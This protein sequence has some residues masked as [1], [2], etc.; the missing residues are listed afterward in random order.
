MPRRKNQPAK[1]RGK[2]SSKR[3]VT[4]AGPYGASIKLPIPQLP[5]LKVGSDDKLSAP[6]AVNPDRVA[7]CIPITPNQATLVAGAMSTALAIGFSSLVPNNT[8]FSAL[9]EEYCLTGLSLEIRYQP[10]A[11]FETGFIVVSIDE[12]D[13]T[14]PTSA[15]LSSPHIEVNCAAYGAGNSYYI[16]WKPASTDDL[17]WTPTSAPVDVAWLKIFAA[18]A[19][20]FTGAGTGRILITGTLTMAFRQFKN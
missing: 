10:A 6:A 5:W 17:S 1:G 13:N 16:D 19:N 3:S 18:A 8:R 20:T 11:Q 12:A 2:K 14:P 7:F 4:I 15:V 9:F